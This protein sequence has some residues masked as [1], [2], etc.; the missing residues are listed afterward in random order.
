[1]NQST[2]SA[3]PGVMRMT[4]LGILCIV[5]G[6]IAIMTPVLTGFSIVMLL[7]AF[8]LVSGIIRI[9]GAFQS[10]SKNKRM[11]MLTVGALTLLIGVV[12]LARP[13]FAIGLLT[14]FLIA[15]L[16]LDGILEIAEGISQR[17]GAETPWLLFGGFV[18][19]L[20]GILLWAQFPL[21]GSW[22]LGVL[23]G[24]KL[25]LIGLVMVT[26]ASALRSMPEGRAGTT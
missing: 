1:M 26:G 15:Y 5:L 6:I 7:G 25:F 18:S 19:V 21:S 2:Q 22:A 20:L 13:L 11:F 3:N 23:V 4:L 17:S 9:V 8:I 10:D 14:I 16:I 24:I 12:L